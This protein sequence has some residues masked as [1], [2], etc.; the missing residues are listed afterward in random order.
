MLSKGRVWYKYGD[1][2]ENFDFALMYEG[3]KNAPEESDVEFVEA[4]VRCLESMKI[5]Y[6]F[7]DEPEEVHIY[8]VQPVGC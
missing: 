6:S 4:K 8:D 3:L 1:L 7:L 2:V 5:L